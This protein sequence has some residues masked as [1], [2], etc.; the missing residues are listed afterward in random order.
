MTMKYVVGT[1][2]YSSTRGM[3]CQESSGPGFAGFGEVRFGLEQQLPAK[4][5]AARGWKDDRRNESRYHNRAP[6]FAY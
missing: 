3:A 6:V 2:A 1:G 4:T 5:A